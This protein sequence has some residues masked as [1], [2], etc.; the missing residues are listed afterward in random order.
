VSVA[1]PPDPGSLARPWI[2]SYPPGVPPTY[3]LP[4]VA[5]PRFLD[6]AA[7]DF[8]DEPALVT[9]DATVTYLTL[10]ERVDAV[11]QVLSDAGITAADRVLVAAPNVPATLTVLFG[12]WRLGAVAVPVDPELRADRLL[13]VAEDA[14][15]AGVVGSRKALHALAD[16]RA[17]PPVALLVDGTEWPA[18]R[19]LPA[20]PRPSRTRR[21]AAR[22]GAARLSEALG[23]VGAVTAPRQPP[24]PGSP[25]LIAYRPRDRGLRGVVLTHANLVANAFQ[26]RLWVPDIQ[27]GRERMLIAD[28]LYDVA[29]LILGALGGMLSAA[30]LVLLDD[31]DPRELTRAVERHG[32]TLFATGPRRLADLLSGDGDVSSLR[33]VLTTGAPVD[34]QLAADVERRTGG[35][36]VREGYGLAEAATLT[37]AQPVYGRVVPRAI[38]LPVTSTVAAVVDPEDLGTLCPPRQAGLL[39]V[40]GPQVASGYWRRDDASAATFVDGWLITDDLATVDE[41]GVFRH[42][43]RRDEVIDRSGTLVSPRHVE[44]TLERHPLVRRAGVVATEDGAVLIAAVVPRRRSRP[45]PDELLSH[46]RAHLDS[47]AVPDRVT[48]VDELPETEAG[49]LARDE[50]RRDL[51]GR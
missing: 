48:L 35:A 20:L 28:G 29:T 34:P 50:L 49:D 17:T 45:D 39:I 19:R 42:V 16:R 11:A 46:C 47:P 24:E 38:G 32:P 33:A 8:P 22:E 6:D 14:E 40:Y 31:P 51:V 41:D 27:A 43:G 44:T 25:A 21:A 4:T 9:A 1:T 3:R 10:R 5:I 2:G 15:V 23:T 37:H 18:R 26:A 12:L 30:A 36:R 7:R 13:R